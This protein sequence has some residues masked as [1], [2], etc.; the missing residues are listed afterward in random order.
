M[1]I[2]GP[3]VAVEVLLPSRLGR[4]F[5]WL[6]GSSFTSN[7]GDGIALAAGPLLVASLSRD[8]FV[9]ALAALLQWLPPLLFAL[10]AGV[11][12]DRLDRRRLILTV[13]LVRA[14]VVVVLVVLVA[15]GD[16]PVAV[17]LGVLFVQATAEVFVDNTASTLLPMIVHRD[18]LALGNSR[19][20]AS[21]ITVNQLVGPPLGAFLFTLTAFTPF[22]AQAALAGLAAVLVAR[23]RTSAPDADRPRSRIRQ[24]LREGFAWTVRH[25]AVRTLLLTIF[26]FNLTYGAAWSLLVLYAR[27]RLGLGAVGFG[28]VSTTIAAGGLLGTVLYGRLTRW[29]SLGTIMRAGLVVE[30][31][32]HLVLALTRNPFVAL[33][34][35]FVFGVHAFVWGTTSITVR[36]RAVPLPLQGRVTALN[37][38]ATY[39]GL[40]LG[41]AIGGFLAQHLGITAPF[42]WGFLGSAVFLVLIWRSLSR[43]AHSDAAR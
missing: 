8:P 35:F 24:D 7:L 13:D 42:W 25:D 30:T 15:S 31:L 26:V 3:A 4:S 36:Q 10:P 9:V 28:L 27:D 32:T 34:V 11:L 2:P 43:I 38:V 33:P 17:V 12:S 16:P 20:Q 19:L 23:I 5:R 22:A 37:S 29:T 39:G 6:L 41:A 21:F 40:V 1:R 14:A 18:D